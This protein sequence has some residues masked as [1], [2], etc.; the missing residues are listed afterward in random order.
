MNAVDFRS[1]AMTTAAVSAVAAAGMLTLWWRDRRPELRDWVSGYLLLAAGNLLLCLRGGG[2]ASVAVPAGHLLVVWAYLRLHDGTRRFLGRPPLSRSVQSAAL[3]AVALLLGWTTWGAADVGARAV[4]VAVAV[5]VLCTDVSRLLWRAITRET[6]PAVVLAASAFAALA[7]VKLG[8]AG[9]ASLA[10]SDPGALPFAGHG[11]GF[12]ATT[13]ATVGTMAGFATLHAQRL[14]QQLS[15]LARSDQ[16]TG[17][18]NRRALE[19]AAAAEV[20]RAARADSPLWVFM[21]DIDH[22]KAVNDRHGHQEGDRVL[23]RVAQALQGALRPYDVLG[24]YGGEEFA[25]LLPGLGPPAALAAAERL[26]EAVAR[27][28]AAGGAGPVTV[29]IGG[30]A[31]GR[32]ERGWGAAVARADA[33]LYEAKSEGRD[34]VVIRTPPMVVPAEER[35]RKL[36]GA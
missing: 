17:L 15:Q 7:A 33:A 13:L 25:V 19:E 4:V 28:F 8:Q 32:G 6:W 14:V 23:Q 27:P 1:A 12:L 34:R 36:H 9:L 30:A 31:F 3:A 24:R 11:V 22:F 29:S 26:R 21:I 16:L 10:R 18:L 20:E 35:P 5:G 2:A